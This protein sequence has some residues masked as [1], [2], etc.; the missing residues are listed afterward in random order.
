MGNWNISLSVLIT[1]KKIEIFVS[2]I[3]NSRTVVYKN[4]NLRTEKTPS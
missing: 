2:E 3:K 4:K 1:T